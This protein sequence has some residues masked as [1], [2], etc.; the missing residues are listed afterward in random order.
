[1]ENK[2][3]QRAI[4]E[5]LKWRAV[6]SRSEIMD[7]KSGLTRIANPTARISELRRKWYKIENRTEWRNIDGQRVKFSWYTWENQEIGIC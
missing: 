3:Q 7:I 1:M 4:L 2:N 6:V 5:L